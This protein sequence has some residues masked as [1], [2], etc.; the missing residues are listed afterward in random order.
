MERFIDSYLLEWKDRKKHKPL[1]IRGARQVGKTYTVEMFARKAFP[2]LIK[3]NFE[4]EDLSDFFKTN[5][6]TET[7]QNLE[8]HLGQ[9]IIPGKT[10][11]F[12]DEIQ[13]CPDAIVSL[14]YF[15]EKMPELHIIAAGSLLDHTLN[16]MTGPMPVGRVEFAYMQPMN[17]HE[18]LVA[19][20][21]KELYDFLQNYT[22]DKGIPMPL[23]KKLL[24]LVRLYYFIGGMPEAVSAYVENNG[25]PEVER[26]HESII[27]TLEYDFGKYGTRQQQEVLIKLLRYIP[28]GLGKKFKYVRVDNTLRAER[29]KHALKLLK[30]SRLV[31]LVHNTRAN[32]IPLE[33]GRDERSFKPI[34]LDT[35]LANHLLRLR[36][37]NIDD[38][39]TI[40][41]GGLAEQFVGQQLYSD[42]PFY[43]DPEVFYWM[44]EKRNAEAEIDYLIE[45]Q[46]RIVPVEVKAG[47][48]GTLKSLH[49]FMAEKH[50]ATALRFNTDLPSLARVSTSVKTGGRVRNVDFDLIS[51]PLYLVLE[52]R[53]LVEDVEKNRP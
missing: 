7:V 37:T 4:E 25:L 27:R 51:L 10:L 21:E 8:I 31:H 38:L 11:L 47:K 40:N 46:N 2:D 49:V 18:F 43:L 16:E 23:H 24:R 29:I 3:I 26:I 30:M 32:G 34:F 22:L 9:R 35:G 36:L 53:R 1:V 15:H 52:S 39:V 12:L 14:R 33:Q 45:T 42:F 50:L 5:R 41:E 19:L 6:I 20:G 13:A 28:R 48:T 17:F 44:R